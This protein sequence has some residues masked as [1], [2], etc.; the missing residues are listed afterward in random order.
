MYTPYPR[1]LEAARFRARGKRQVVDHLRLLAAFM[2]HNTHAAHV[3]EGL[4]L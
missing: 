2:L 1:G 4:Q 3:T